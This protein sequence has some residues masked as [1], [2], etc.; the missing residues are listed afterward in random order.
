MVAV[1][2]LLHI[3]LL[4]LEFHRKAQ[5]AQLDAWLAQV[6]KHRLQAAPHGFQLGEAH[7]EV[8]LVALQALLFV[9]LEVEPGEGLAETAGG[10]KGTVEGLHTTELLREALAAEWHIQ[11]SP[12]HPV[13][14][15]HRQGVRQPL[16]RGIKNPAVDFLLER[17]EAY[18]YGDLAGGGLAAVAAQGAIPDQPIGAFQGDARIGRELASL[19]VDVAA[20][21][22]AN[23][24]NPGQVGE[25]FAQPHSNRLKDRALTRAVFANDQGEA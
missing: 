20:T 15:Q 13:M 17:F 3:E 19:L 25:H 10:L 22:K 23:S 4:T 9:F 2:E 11:Q 21:A 6:W 12:A 14:H 8:T 18:S 7:I 24:R 5:G 16:I 1:A